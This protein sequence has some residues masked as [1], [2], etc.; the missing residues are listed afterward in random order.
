[1]FEQNL[2]GQ[3]LAR[4]ESL[5]RVQAISAAAGAASRTEVARRICREFEFFDSWRRPQVASCLKALRAL[6]SKG[7][8]CIPAPRVLRRTR[9]RREAEAAGPVPLPAPVDVPSSVELV[10]GLDIVPA[11]SPHQR[12]LCQR[13]I[14]GEHPRGAVR[15][16]G[17]QMRYLILSEHGI[18][19]AAVFAASALAL[20]ER[21]RWIG[22]DRNTRLRHL[23]RI[24]G[25]SRFLV[26]PSVRCRNLAS[27]ALSLCLRRLPADFRQRYNYRPWLVETFADTSQHSGTCFR[28][29]N[30][31]CVGR[32]A[33][34]GRFTPPGTQVP[35]QRIFLCPLNPRWRRLLNLSGPAPKPP[36]E[37]PESGPLGPADGL[38]PD[39]WARNEFGGAPLGDVRLGRRLVRSASVQS[40]KPMASFPRAAEGELALVRGHY[41]L[42]RWTI[43]D[44]EGVRRVERQ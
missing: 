15:H 26:R 24:V 2:I 39:Q 40:A 3:T 22:W 1:M 17:A 13:L 38:N 20:R 36:P 4:P 7:L 6:E 44:T 8:A 19:G 18:L 41:R 16:V 21:D 25:L 42:Y 43:V 5:G 37:R 34:R 11:L 14:A 31:I 9:A 28:A 33:G 32:T 23:H 12:Q 27:K 10:R 30:F 29:A 35:P